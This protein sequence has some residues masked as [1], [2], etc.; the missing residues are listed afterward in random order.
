MFAKSGWDVTGH[1]DLNPLNLMTLLIGVF[2]NLK[3]FKYINYKGDYYFS[4][5]RSFGL[6]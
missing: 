6:W 5:P 2:F 1:I 4:G 3:L